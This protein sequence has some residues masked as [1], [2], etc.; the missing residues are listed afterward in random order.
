GNVLLPPAVET[1]ATG[2]ANPRLPQ[3]S[4]GPP[5]RL[6][7]GY[8]RMMPPAFTTHPSVDVS[9]RDLN[10]VY[11]AIG[12]RPVIR[13]CRLSVRIAPESGR[14]ANNNGWPRSARGLNRSRGRALRAAGTAT[15]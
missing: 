3:F 15:R 9:P 10:P 5:K 4:H 2:P 12:A 1:R 8:M 6:A 7:V 14:A 13:R 11:V